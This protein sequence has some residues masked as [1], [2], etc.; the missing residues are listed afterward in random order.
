MVSRFSLVFCVSFRIDGIATL[1]RKI[2][3]SNTLSCRS[4]RYL[5]HVLLILKLNFTLRRNIEVTL[6][7][8][9]GTKSIMLR[10]GKK[11]I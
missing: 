3:I 6:T 10:S 1:S 4:I 7:S 5:E 2:N 8:P 9:A 11:M